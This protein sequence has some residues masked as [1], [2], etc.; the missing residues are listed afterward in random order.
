MAILLREAG[1]G[2]PDMSAEALAKVEGVEGQVS[3]APSL[4]SIYRHH[5]PPQRQ[6]AVLAAVLAV[7][8]LAVA[9]LVLMLAP[10]VLLLL[11]AAVAMYR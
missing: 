3:N 1:E 9:V 4:H 2:D 10:L 11:V 7:A 8:V 6:A 5:I